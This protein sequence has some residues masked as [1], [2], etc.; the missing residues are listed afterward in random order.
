MDNYGYGHGFICTFPNGFA[1]SDSAAC[2]HMRPAAAD[3]SAETSGSSQ[4][5]LGPSF[6]L[7]DAPT[8]SMPSP[9]P[10]PSI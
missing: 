9:T 6:G 7:A 4:E 2:G 5:L 8:P 1:L 3:S 10:F